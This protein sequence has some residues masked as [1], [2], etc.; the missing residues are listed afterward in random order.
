MDLPF[1]MSLLL[2]LPFPSF[3]SASHP[4]VFIPEAVGGTEQGKCQSAVVS[5]PEEAD[6]GIHV[7]DSGVWV[8]A[9]VE[10]REHSWGCRESLPWE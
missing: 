10:Q 1:S 2:L 8:S 7:E 3:P 4:G 6:K 9:Q 5:G